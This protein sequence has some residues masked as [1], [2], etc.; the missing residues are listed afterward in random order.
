MRSS[1]P[2]VVTPGEPLPVGPLGGDLAP[3]LVPISA[4]C[5]PRITTAVPDAFEGV[6]DAGVA[7]E[8]PFRDVPVVRA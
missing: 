1:I 5:A 3:D 2:G 8:V 4:L 7:I 6:E